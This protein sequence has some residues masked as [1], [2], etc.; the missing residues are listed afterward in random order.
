LCD[1][2]LLLGRSRSA[3]AVASAPFAIS[4]M[5]TLRFGGLG[6]VPPA[7][8]REFASDSQAAASALW[9]FLLIVLFCVGEDPR[10]KATIT[11][12][13]SRRRRA[14]GCRRL[15]SPFALL[16]KAPGRFAKI[17][18]VAFQPSWWPSPLLGLGESLALQQ[19]PFGVPP[20]PK[21]RRR[22]SSLK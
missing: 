16:A 8:C 13:G 3:L 12:H 5:R 15:P 19:Q 11:E 6:N 2:L 20:L 7:A 21:R 10:A 22:W 17:L 9:L 18:L 14:S 4:P 1:P